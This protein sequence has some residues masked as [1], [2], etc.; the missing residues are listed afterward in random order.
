MRP[1]VHVKSALRN[2]PSDVLSVSSE[3]RQP[4]DKPAR[5]DLVQRVQRVDAKARQVVQPLRQ[6]VD[7]IEV[8]DVRALVR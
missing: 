2:R 6:A 3:D 1:Q 8:Q 7:R 4:L 5:L